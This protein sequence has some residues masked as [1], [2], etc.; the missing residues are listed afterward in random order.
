MSNCVEELLDQGPY[1]PPN[2]KVGILQPESYFT[3]G[4]IEES[5]HRGLLGVWDSVFY[6]EAKGMLS[7]LS[8]INLS[9]QRL[10]EENLVD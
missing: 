2:A 7:T 10:K 6:V 8:G 4:D 1:I 9:C 5:V 3:L